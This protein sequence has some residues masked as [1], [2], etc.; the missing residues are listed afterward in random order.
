MIFIAQLEPAS[1]AKDSYARSRNIISS[2]ITKGEENN[3]KF[4]EIEK[5]INKRVSKKDIV[6]YLIK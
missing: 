2:V 4:Y 1:T 6:R 3:I 5:L